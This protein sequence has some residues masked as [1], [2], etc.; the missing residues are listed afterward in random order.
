[1]IT[2]YFDSGKLGMQRNH[3]EKAKSFQ[4]RFLPRGPSG[5][6]PWGDPRVTAICAA[7]W[8]EAPTTEL[9]VFDVPATPSKLSFRCRGE[10]DPRDSM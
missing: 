2:M 6:T 5:P 7:M 3:R 8:T 9:W 10:L 1:M 4:R